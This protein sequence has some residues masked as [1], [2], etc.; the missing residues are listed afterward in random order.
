V[1]VIIMG[2]YTDV[3]EGSEVRRTAIASVPVGDE[4]IG[5]VVDL[6]AARSTPGA[7]PHQRT[8]GR[9]NASPPASMQRESVRSRCR[10]ASRLST[11]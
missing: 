1:S 3:R 8:A 2:D 4:L 6:W 5:R 7:D 10:R 9:W 11:R